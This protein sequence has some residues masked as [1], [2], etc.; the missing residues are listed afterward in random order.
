MFLEDQVVGDAEK[1]DE[2]QSFLQIPIIP[3]SVSS[4]VA[5]DDHEGAGEDNNGGPREPVDQAPLEP[6][7]LPVELE[8]RRSTSEQRPS[9]RYP[10]HEYVMLIDGGEPKCFEEVMSLCKRR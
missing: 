9:T 8:L 3:T 5:H 10:P 4:P 2:S 1:N 7:A 6:P